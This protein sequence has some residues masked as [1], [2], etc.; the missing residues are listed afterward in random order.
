MDE[1]REDRRE[2]RGERKR[3]GGETV[4]EEGKEGRQC[5]QLVCPKTGIA[6]IPQ[7]SAPKF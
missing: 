5:S 1:G 7:R 2:R 4:K 6:Q 3:G